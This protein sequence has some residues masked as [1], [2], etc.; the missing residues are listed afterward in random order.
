[1]EKNALSFDCV[2]DILFRSHY[3]N[4][5]GHWHQLDT[6]LARDFECRWISSFIEEVVPKSVVRK[7][8]LSEFIYLT[9]FVTERKCTVKKYIEH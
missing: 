2:G 9:R 5:K 3:L 7:D 8:H 6:P 1:M 4:S